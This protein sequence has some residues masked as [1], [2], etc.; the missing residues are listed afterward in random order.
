MSAKQKRNKNQPDPAKCKQCNCANT[1]W[2]KFKKFFSWLATLI[3]GGIIIGL[4]FGVINWSLGLHLQ[5]ESR[6]VAKSSSGDTYQ[7]FTSTI[8]FPWL[9]TP[10]LKITG[11]FGDGQFIPNETAMPRSGKCK[12]SYCPEFCFTE[13]KGGGP[14]VYVTF[15]TRL[16]HTFTKQIQIN[17]NKHGVDFTSDFNVNLG[18]IEYAIAIA[19]GTSFKITDYS[20]F[21]FIACPTSFGPK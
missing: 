16:G 7:I 13:E 20:D 17:K 18:A 8:N 21:G 9:Q 15:L 5:K 4:V 1:F 12:K 19:L 2:T 14:Y 6:F 3:G 11:V 10:T